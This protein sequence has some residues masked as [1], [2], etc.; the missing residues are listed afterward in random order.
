MGTEL[1]RTDTAAILPQGG[2]LL[3][4]RL[5]AD[6]LLDAGGH[7]PSELA[8]NLDDIG[9]VN[10][11]GGG[12]RVVL[13]HLPELL[14]GLPWE[15][16]V[17]ILDLGTGGA[18]IPVAVADWLRRRNRSARI[19]ASDVSE[20]VLAVARRRIG[21]RHE[22]DTA[23]YDALAVPLP[24]RAVDIVLSSLT[25]HHFEPEDAARLL[26]EMQRLGRVGFILNDIARSAPGYAVAW[27]ASR[28][29]T[30]NRLTRHDMP[31]SV[32]RAYAPAEL[33][34]LLA[35]AG[36]EGARV[37]THPLFRMA[38]VWRPDQDAAGGTRS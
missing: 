4:S 7:D 26:G 12:V 27:V 9:R 19:V 37:T 30:R 17:E 29:G 15:R 31:L 8:E 35:A 34:A 1:E 38:A 14:D 3:G 20:E 13:R 2:A 32:R 28:L 23:R 21:R 11:L 25:M 22:I 36:I 5:R 6:E 10:R 24:D 33:E 16:P 18:D